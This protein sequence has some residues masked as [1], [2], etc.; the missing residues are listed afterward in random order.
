MASRKE[1]LT[2]PIVVFPFE[3]QGAGSAL[4]TTS[5]RPTCAWPLPTCLLVPP[6][7]VATLAT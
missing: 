1:S 6:L 4:Q 2:G 3:L 7:P 5:Q